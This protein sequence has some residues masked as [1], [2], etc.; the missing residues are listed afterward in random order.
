MPNDGGVVVVAGTG[1]NM[2]NIQNVMEMTVP[3]VGEFT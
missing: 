2:K 1:M 3:T